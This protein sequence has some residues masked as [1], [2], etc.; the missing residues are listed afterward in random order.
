MIEQ[1]DKVHDFLHALL[2][3]LDAHNFDARVFQLDRAFSLDG[4]TPR[5]IKHYQSLCCQFLEMVN[6]TSKTVGRKK[7]AYMGSLSLGQCGRRLLA[8]MKILNCCHQA[9]FTPPLLRL[10]LSLSMDPREFES[11]TEWQLRILV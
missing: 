3:I 5:N 7:Y 6:G 8:L 10:L 4:A 9:P 11:L 1:E 2:P